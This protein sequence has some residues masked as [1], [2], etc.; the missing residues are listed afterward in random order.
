MG[1]YLPSNTYKS[2]TYCVAKSANKLSLQSIVKSIADTSSTPSESELD[3][4]IT[5]LG[6]HHEQSNSSMTLTLTSLLGISNFVVLTSPCAL[7]A[8]LFLISDFMIIF[9]VLT[10]F[11]GVWF[12]KC[13]P[14]FSLYDWSILRINK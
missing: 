12:Q 1:N 3:I 13:G 5:G 6:V 9:N 10:N 8:V 14:L 7:S 11:Y 4:T 2:T